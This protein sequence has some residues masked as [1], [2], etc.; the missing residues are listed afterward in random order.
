MNNSKKMKKKNEVI[1]VVSEIS[2]LLDTGLNRS[3]LSAVYDLLDDGGIHP[4]A[5]AMS[6]LEM[7][8]ES[9]EYQQEVKNQ[10]QRRTEKSRSKF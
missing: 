1:E 2:E 5:L 8:K 3:A 6:V 4:E 10:T 9:A 7:R